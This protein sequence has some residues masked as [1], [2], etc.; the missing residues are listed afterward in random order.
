MIRPARKSDASEMVALIDCAGYGIPLW[1]WGGMRKDEPSVLEVGRQ[2]AMREAGGFPT[3]TPSSSRRAVLFRACSS[4]TG[5][6][7]LMR[8]AI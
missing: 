8:R 4:A 1:V 7:I 5:W 6:T 3:A 2:R